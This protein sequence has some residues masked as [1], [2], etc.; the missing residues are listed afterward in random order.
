MANKS[1]ERHPGGHKH[2]A[3]RMW[4]LK[5]WHKVNKSARRWYEGVELERTQEQHMSTYTPELGQA[6]FGNEFKDYEVPAYV[7]SHL[8]AIKDELDRVMWNRDQREYD[9]PFDNSGNVPGVVCDVFEAH[10]YDWNEEDGQPFN[11]KW[12]D[13]EICWYKYLGRGMSMNRETSPKE[14]ALML[15]ECLAAIRLIGLEDK[16]TCPF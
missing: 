1:D 8:V 6:L 12:R 7:K 9:S 14:A 2:G 15:E 4:C 3:K 10:A 13:L 16:D 5:E 11:F